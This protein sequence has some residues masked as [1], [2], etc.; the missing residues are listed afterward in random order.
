MTQ[1]LDNSE[2]QNALALSQAACY[3][4][5]SAKEHREGSEQ[6]NTMLM[7]TYKLA[8]MTVAALDAAIL[9]EIVAAP[10]EPTLADFIEQ[11]KAAAAVGEPAPAIVQTVAIDPA[12]TETPPA[13][14]MVTPHGEPSNLEGK[15]SDL[16]LP[17]DATTAIADQSIT[18]AD[19]APATLGGV[20]YA[21]L[22]VHPV[23]PPSVSPLVGD[24]TN[25]AQV[26]APTE[27]DL[28]PA[29]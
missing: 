7:L 11:A 12:N 14:I 10:G 13:F 3:A 24:I 4:S 8:N 15:D 1:K 28:A 9:P 6:A 17:V 29:L 27:V 25:T 19:P 16:V 2:L 22:P 5:M 18:L 20:D 26:A 21:P 23:A